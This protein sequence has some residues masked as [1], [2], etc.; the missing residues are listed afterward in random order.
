MR[1]AR[2]V[3]CDG[4]YSSVEGRQK[5]NDETQGKKKERKILV[6]NC[7]SPGGLKGIYGL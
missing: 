3:K 7:L 5:K 6:I 4:S 1:P 2:T